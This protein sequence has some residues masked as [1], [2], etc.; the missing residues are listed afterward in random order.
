MTSDPSVYFSPEFIRDFKDLSRRYD[1]FPEDFDRML[2]AMRTDRLQSL[3]I[4][5]MPK[6]CQGFSVQKFRKFHSRDLKGGCRSGIRII[7]T[8]YNG[9]VLFVECYQKGTRENENK[10]RICG[11]LSTVR[12][13]SCVG[14][15]VKMT[16][17][18]SRFLRRA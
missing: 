9:C 8:E 6:G 2:E 1:N 3:R 16:K 12:D 10:M 18:N 15:Y 17:P 13:G 5:N 7:Y 14:R 11:S 4:P